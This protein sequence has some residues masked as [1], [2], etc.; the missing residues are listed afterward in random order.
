MPGPHLITPVTQLFLTAN[1][2]EHRE[3]EIL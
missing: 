3:T 2:K 1:F